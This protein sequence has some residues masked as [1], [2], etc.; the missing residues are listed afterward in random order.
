MVRDKDLPYGAPVI[1]AFL[2][3]GENQPQHQSEPVR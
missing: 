1:A 3:F 2:G